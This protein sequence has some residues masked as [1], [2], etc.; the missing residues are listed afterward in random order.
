MPDPRHGPSDVPDFRYRLAPDFWVISSYY[1]P[2][3][4]RSRRSNYDLF[5]R[6]LRRSGLPL[7]TVECAFGQ[8]AFDLEE[9]PEIVR[10]RSQSVIWQKERLLNLAVSWLPRSA[11]YVAWLDCDLLFA[12]P[13]WAADTARLLDRHPLVQVFETCNRLPQAPLAEGRLKGDACPS[14]ASTVVRDPALLKL[15]HF[16]KHGHTGYGWAAR[17]EVLDR[18]GLYEYA[19]VG[20]ADH[21]MAHAACGDFSGPCLQ[22]ATAGDRRQIRHYE[23]WA[24]QFFDAVRGNIGCTPGEV[25][26][27][28][29]GDL[30]NRRYLVRNRELSK[31]G[32]N[33]YQ[34]VVAPP[35][36]PLEWRSPSENVELTAMLHSYFSARQEDGVVATI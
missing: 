7:L 12:N 31:L 25:L 9:T 28:W 34:D 1:N 30:E 29:H 20:S 14:F 10:V 32:F 21:Y 19:I 15:G 23:D 6:A 22:L 36:K 18:C 27:L 5:A 16:E 4:Y 35:G 3:H 24:K 13:D 17:R 33:P 8:E 11:R 26:H 2:C